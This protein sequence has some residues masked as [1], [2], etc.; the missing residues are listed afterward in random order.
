MNGAEDPR[1]TDLAPDTELAN[2]D[3]ADFEI[4]RASLCPGESASTVAPSKPAGLAQCL[5]GC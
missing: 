5:H 2:C 4:G 3:C 1:G